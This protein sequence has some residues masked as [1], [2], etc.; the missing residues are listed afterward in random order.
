M[1]LINKI[2][3]LDKRQ[4]IIFSSVIVT[5][6]LISTQLVDFSLRFRFMAAL[7]VLSYILSFW[8][9]WV[10]IYEPEAFLK[11]NKT[12][13]LT[14][15]ILPAL[16]AL[17]VASFY[18]LLPIRWLTRIPVAVLFGSAFYLLLLVQNLFN[19]ASI[20]TIP[21]YRAASTAAFLY[22]LITAF[23][24]FNVIYA[25]NMLFIWNGVIVFLLSFPLILQLLW[26]VEM[27]DRLSVL[28][29]VQAFVLSLVIGEFSMLFS[30]WPLYSMIW[31]L[32]LASIMYVVVG[33]TTE[34]MRGRLNRRV[35]QEYIG[36][37]TAIFIVAYLFTGWS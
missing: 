11:I 21:L 34:N 26:S 3:S 29:L 4:K 18:F 24:L 19:V 25:F 7:A 9:L 27:E 20:R 36:I 37:V 28:L 5:A 22:T 33:L 8:S 31:A 17:A 1:N 12:K 16:F 13:A 2:T 15:L 32:S 23:L 6:G 14:L 10:G 30:F 35:V